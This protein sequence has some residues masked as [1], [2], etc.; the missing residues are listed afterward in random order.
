[1][2]WD[3]R[4]RI[5][6]QPAVGRSVLYALLA[7]HGPAGYAVSQDSRPDSLDLREI[8]QRIE[9]LTL[10]LEE[11]RLGS[12]VVARADTSV[13]G[14]GPAASRVYGVQQGVSIGGY[15]EFVYENFSDSREDGTPSGRTDQADALRGIIYVGY[16]FDDQ[17]LF[18]S[19][20]ELEHGS[21]D[22][23]GSASLE[24]AYLDY[25][26]REGFGFR[27]GLLLS[28]MGFV[29]ELHE[30]PVFLGAGRPVTESRIIPSTWRENG[31]GF[32]GQAGS[33]DYRFYLMNSLDGVGGGSSEAA[34]FSASGLRGGRQKG[35]KALAENFSAVGRVDWS[36]ILGLTAGASL[37]AGNS[38]HGR[39]LDNGTTV[40][41]RTL[42]WE[43]HVEY[44]A[45][46]LD[47]RALFALADVDDAEALNALNGL[48][49]SASVGERLRG[50]YVQVGYDLLTSAP[51]SHQLI[52]FLRYESV[53]TQA[54]VPAG[55]T[56]DGASDL[57]VVTLGLSWK[58]LTQIVG[59]AD[60]QVNQ[61]GAGTG[62]DQFNVALGYLF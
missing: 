6:L 29:N 2:S 49:G 27:G 12:D 36:G 47:V 24:F 22:R 26:L 19:E 14:F 9:A 8:E 38:G 34:G 45:N 51:T 32:F 55:F 33:F 61:T 41:A 31:L 50:A 13:L 37:Y 20:I 21:T 48:T 46:G 59:K 53:D 16:K 28:P 11:L 52:P 3:P 58:P 42:I 30:P 10:E 44:Q 56:A 17:F 57:T 4:L 40:D 7:L 23:A 54:R 18:N 25:R 60:Y 1:M 43:G 39:T 35:S 5:R 15:G 62:V